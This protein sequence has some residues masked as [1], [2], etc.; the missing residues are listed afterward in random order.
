MKNLRR[1]R[2]DWPEL[3]YL[4]FE[5]TPLNMIKTDVILHIKKKRLLKYPQLMKTPLDRRNKS[6]YYQLHHD[7]G[8]DM[9]DYCDLKEQIKE[10]ICQEYLGKFI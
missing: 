4:R 8:H 3:P 7:Y 10:L 6:K 5:S 2:N 9:E 1:R